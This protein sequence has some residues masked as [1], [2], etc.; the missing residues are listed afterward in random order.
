MFTECAAEEKRYSS[1]IALPQI[2][3]NCE[4][5]TKTGSFRAAGAE[6]VQKRCKLDILPGDINDD[7]EYSGNEQRLKHV[8]AMASR[9]TP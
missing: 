1:P 2:S 8:R 9:I 6:L 5:G 4:I 7:Y 3:A